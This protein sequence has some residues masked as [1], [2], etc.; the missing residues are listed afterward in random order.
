MQPRTDRPKYLRVD[1]NRPTRIT[2]SFARNPNEGHAPASDLG[3]HGAEPHSVGT[4]GLVLQLR[5]ALPRPHLA[6]RAAPAPAR[7][8]D[9][10][11]AP[12]SGQVREDRSRGHLRG[13]GGYAARPAA[14]SPRHPDSS[15]P[16]RAD[17]RAYRRRL[18]LF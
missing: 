1:P 2:R 17:E 3:G 15:R 12:P 16:L 6:E 10:G 14:E 13:H 7:R 9:L 18:C 5:P 8:R 4:E 11:R